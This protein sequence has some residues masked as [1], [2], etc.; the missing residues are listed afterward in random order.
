MIGTLYRYPHPHDPTRFIY[1]GQG[2]NRDA[3][4]RLGKKGFGLRFKNKFLGVELPQPIREQVEVIDQLELNE[5]ETIWMFRY[6]TWRGYPDGE[7]LVLPGSAD[8]RVLGKIGGFK[9]SLIPG[10]LSKVGKKSF[11][12]HGSPAT[13]ESCSKGGKIQ[14]QINVQSG[15]MSAIGREWGRKAVESGQI[16]TLAT[17]ESC[18]KGGRVA[19]QITAKERTGIHGR[20]LQQKTED[21]CK[22]GKVAGQKT[23]ENR[24]GIHGV[25]A[26]QRLENCSKGGKVSGRTN[27]ESGHMERIRSLIPPEVMSKNGLAVCCLRWNVRRGKPCTCG[28]HIKVTEA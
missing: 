5:L 18:A 11:D 20:S 7:N 22:G 8:Y 1:V 15:H 23:F 14:G 13:I 25:P 2:P 28:K 19:G 9:T 4:H 27:V 6:H 21:A 26:Q 3:D 17:P 12:L 16:K 24:T 10:H